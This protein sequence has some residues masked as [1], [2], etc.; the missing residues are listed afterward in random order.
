MNHISKHKHTHTH[1]HTQKE[2]K[3][4]AEIYGQH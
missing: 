3:K 2:F 4:V 1:T